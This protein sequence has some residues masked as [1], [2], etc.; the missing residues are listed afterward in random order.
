MA[1]L[2]SR[3]VAAEAC[4]TALSVVMLGSP[5]GKTSKRTPLRS[6]KYSHFL[7]HSLVI[8]RRKTMRNLHTAA[9]HHAHGNY[10]DTHTHT[11]TQ[12]ARSE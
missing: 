5:T 6:C 8:Q 10:V 3:R 11:C 4:F 2:L 9:A 12:K 7:V 1:G